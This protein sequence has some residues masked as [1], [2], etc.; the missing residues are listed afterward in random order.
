MIYMDKP[1]KIEFRGR[2]RWH[3]HLWS[4]KPGMEGSNE[5]RVFA[6]WLGMSRRWLQHPGTYKEHYDLLS[7]SRCKQAEED[8][9][10]VVTTRDWVRHTM[11]KR[12]KDVENGILTSTINSKVN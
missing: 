8:G 5:L 3:S 4:D 2:P 6:E 10:K 11:N 12:V 1:K 9:A 7:Y